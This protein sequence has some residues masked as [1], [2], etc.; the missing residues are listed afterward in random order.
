MGRTFTGTI[1]QRTDFSYVA[2]TDVG[3]TSYVDDDSNYFSRAFTSGT[4]ENQANRL[5]VGRFVLSAASTNMLLDLAGA[6]EDIYGDA[7]TM[8]DVKFLKV[9]NRGVRDEDGDYNPTAGADIT[10][11][12][13]DSNAMGSIF[14]GDQEAKLLVRSGGC[15]MLVAPLDGY[16]VTAGSQDVLEIEYVGSEASGGDVMV[17]VELFGD[18]LTA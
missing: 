3:V 9:R 15:F 5:Y 2:A 4:G 6:L 8:Q 14:Y 1:T 16:P 7:I 18:D 12:G 13:A 17:D 11:G 10:V